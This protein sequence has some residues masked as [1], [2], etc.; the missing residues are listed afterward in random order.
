MGQKIFSER[1]SVHVSTSVSVYNLDLQF[2]MAPFLREREK[3]GMSLK[4]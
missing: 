1:M 3:L 4:M 2:D